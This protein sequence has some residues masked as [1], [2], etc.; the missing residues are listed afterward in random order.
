MIV[1]FLKVWVANYSIF[2]LLLS[3]SLQNFIFKL[4]KKV[5]I[6]AQFPR[7]W[8]R[9]YWL[10]YILSF[11]KN[12]SFIE[13][14]GFHVL[15]LIRILTLWPILHILYIKVLFIIFKNLLNRIYIDIVRP[16]RMNHLW[17]IKYVF[18]FNKILMIPK[19]NAIITHVRLSQNCL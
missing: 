7:Y 18:E 17:L 6:L 8:L 9:K 3:I 1:A 16:Q 4:L 13:V 15:N 2:N 19:E 14:R 10:F 5:A 11:L 12:S